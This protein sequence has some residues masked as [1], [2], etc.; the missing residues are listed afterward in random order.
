[1][2]TKTA[3][4]D[5][6]TFPD[7]AVAERRYVGKRK[8]ATYITLFSA[9]LTELEE[10]FPNV[11]APLSIARV[12]QRTNPFTKLPV[13]VEVFEPEFGPPRQQQ[14]LFA[15]GGPAAVKPLFPQDDD[16]GR[17]LRSVVPARLRSLPHIGTKNVSFADADDLL[18]LD[19][20]RPEMFVECLHGEG[21]VDV[22]SSQLVAILRT[23]EPEELKRRF[24]QATPELPLEWFRALLFAPSS[25]QRFLC[26]WL[27]A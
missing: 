3:P 19:D 1:V 22:A 14:S 9:T 6:S 7:A 25:S 26:A 12:V 27:R 10:R 17:Y 20:A 18:G 15:E 24:P 5:A 13:W 21:I 8:L 11:A 4:P 23:L 2:N 16:Y